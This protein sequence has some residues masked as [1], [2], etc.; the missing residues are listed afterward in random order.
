MISDL[1]ENED[2]SERAVEAFGLKGI[3][4]L[5]GPTQLPAM[6]DTSFGEVEEPKLVDSYRA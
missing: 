3:D 6:N 4:D 5:G 1:D 2:E